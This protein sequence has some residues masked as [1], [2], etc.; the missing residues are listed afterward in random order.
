ME[1]NKFQFR[2]QIYKLK[3]GTSMGNP[4]SCFIANI[5]MSNFELRLKRRNQ[6]PRLWVRYVDDV[7]AIIKRNQINNLLQILTNIHE[8]IKFTCEVEEDD[9]IAFLDLIVKKN[10]GKLEFD[11]YR[12]PTTTMRYTT[13][14]SF[15]SKAVKMSAFHSMVHCLRKVPLSITN[16]MKEVTYIKEAASTNGFKKTDIDLLIHKH[17]NKIKKQQYSTFFNNK[18]TIAQHRVKFNYTGRIANKLKTVFKKKNLNIAFENKNKLK[19][20]LGNPKDVIT[21]HDKSGIYEVTCPVCNL[22]YI[23]QSKRK[24]I[25]RF[26]EHIKFIRLNQPTK[27]A[28]AQHCLTNIT[29]GITSE[30]LK[31]IKNTSTKPK[32]DAWESYFITRRGRTHELMNNSPAPISS[33]LLNIYS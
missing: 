24:I 33:Q 19:N 4:L 26:E 13:N 16:Y 10:N 1:Q 15:T 28:I 12:K 5:F 11:I 32:L 27:S 29:H 30:N 25:T 7:F 3:Y 8:T 14:D 2:D 31:L 17:S 22:R 6:L 21:E 18:T 9:Q 23:G 20:I